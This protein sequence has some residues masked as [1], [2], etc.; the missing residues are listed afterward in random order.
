MNRLLLVTLLVV[1]SAC[2]SS[3]NPSPVT[4]TPSPTPTPTTPAPTPL[5]LSVTIGTPSPSTPRVGQVVTFP[6]TFSVPAGD[7]IQLVRID[8]DGNA[9]S[10]RST[11]VGTGT[12][13][14]FGLIY[15]SAGMF[16]VTVTAT[17]TA[18]NTATAVAMVFIS[19]N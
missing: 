7:L 1:A 18:G 16:V 2:G 17:D 8:T 15:A 6:L 12:P 9:A 13:S 3:H 14:S 4:P 10:V 19:Q 11:G 5:S